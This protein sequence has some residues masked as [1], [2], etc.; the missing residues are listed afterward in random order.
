MVIADLGLTS[1]NNMAPLRLEA[2]PTELKQHIIITTGSCETVMKLRQVSK[3]WKRIASDPFLYKA[4]IKN[5]SSAGWS[6]S[7]LSL[8]APWFCWV[9]YA[10]ADS[11]A[12]E[13]ARLTDEHAKTRTRES[14]EQAY[15]TLS[16]FFNKKTYNWIPQLMTGQR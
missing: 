12:A 9:R 10:L 13:L 14:Q 8:D 2:L 1:C 7:S 16:R 4:I 5:R 11:Q 3:S 15:F 6:T